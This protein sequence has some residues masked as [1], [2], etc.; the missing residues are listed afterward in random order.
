[1]GYKLLYILAP[2]LYMI[3][4]VSLSWE[5]HWLTNTRSFRHR[6]SYME[7]LPAKELS[8]QRMG[9]SVMGLQFWASTPTIQDDNGLSA[10]QGS[11]ESFKAQAH[12]FRGAL[13]ALRGVALPA[14]GRPAEPDSSTTSPWGDVAVPL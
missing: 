14:A 11:V 9:I 13:G 2:F 7:V 6:T 3:R 4:L 12:G 5:S 8:Q 1:M 10:A